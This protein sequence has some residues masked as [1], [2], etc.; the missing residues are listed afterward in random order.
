[1]SR[2]MDARRV[3]CGSHTWRFHLILLGC[4]LLPLSSFAA[5]P[6]D[7]G[8]AWEIIAPQAAL[9]PESGAVPLTPVGRKRYLENKHNQAKGNYDAYDWATSR[10][11]SPG[12]PR[13]MLTSDRFRIWQRPGLLMFQFEWNRLFRQ[14]ELPGLLKEQIRVGSVAPVGGYDD[15][16]TGRSVPIAKGHWEGD[17]IVATTEGFSEDTLI[18]NLIPHGDK[19]KLT[20]RIRLKDADTL[21]DRITVEDPDYFTHPW[22]TVIVYKRQPDVAF[23]E[24]VCLVS[25][26]D[27]RAHL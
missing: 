19:L 6:V 11:A 16:F 15:V 8:G 27:G 25:R 21:E 9:T 3:N 23:P 14:I 5:D 22:Q 10:C 24:N 7:F 26:K 4:V 12:L 20:E 1:M 17:T 13:L 18:D 2:V